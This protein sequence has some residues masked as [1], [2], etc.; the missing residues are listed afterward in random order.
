VRVF[1]VAA[2]EIHTATATA[3]TPINAVRL[4]FI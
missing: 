3:A 4:T 2:A 1:E